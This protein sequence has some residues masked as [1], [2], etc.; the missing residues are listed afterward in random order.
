MSG[1]CDFYEATG[2]ALSSLR[3]S[4]RRGEPSRPCTRWSGVTCDTSGEYV[5]AVNLRTSGLVGSLPPT[6]GLVS[7]L[8]VLDLGS[9][10]LYG[11]IPTSLGLLSQLTDLRLNSNAFSGTIPTQLGSAK[12]LK[13]ININ[14]IKY[15]LIRYYLL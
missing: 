5:I 4:C 9:N 3:W 10:S 13:R 14:I 15:C 12:M 11:T 6:L 1:L 7:S 2:G 8:Q